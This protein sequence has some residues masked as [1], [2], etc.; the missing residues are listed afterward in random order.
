VAACGSLHDSASSG[1]SSSL[2]IDEPVAPFPYNSR[3]W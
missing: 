1:G 3:F 2:L